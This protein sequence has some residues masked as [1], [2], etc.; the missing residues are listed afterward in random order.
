MK[1]LDKFLLHDLSKLFKQC[2]IGFVIDDIQAYNKEM[3]S[4]RIRC[5]DIM[6]AMEKIG[7]N[8]ELC[9]P[10]KK[11]DTV[12]FTK[13][14]TDAAVKKAQKLAQTDTLVISDNFCEYLTDES[15]ADDW[16]RR[17]ILKILEYSDIAFAYSK[18]QYKQFRQYH[19]NVYF[20]NEG[21]NDS[22]FE[23]HKKHEQKEQVT[24]IYSGYRSN[25]LHTELIKNAILRLQREFNCKVTFICEGDPEIKS[26]TYEYIPYEQKKIRSCLLQGDIM[27]A[28]RPMQ[29]IEKA[30][31]TLTKIACP[32]AIG[33]PVVA[34]PVPS[35][36][37]TP[38]ILC[39][40]EEEWYESLKKLIISVDERRKAGEESR[41]YVRK[42]LA[43][44]V[45]AKEYL[46]IIKSYKENR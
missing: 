1:T 40:N 38:A 12:I 6:T 41:E 30:Q 32:M 7:I 9:K 44:D 46:L 28:P 13:T 19:K 24:L 26:F 3:P 34:S 42:H 33:L 2:E 10:H 23:V 36:I 20:I 14:R 5:Y 39:Y 16:E 11:Y 37:D 8:V 21:V 43:T 27:I 45:I 35:Y 31:H 25:A 29:D 22:Y 4:V 17:N 18:E 15:R